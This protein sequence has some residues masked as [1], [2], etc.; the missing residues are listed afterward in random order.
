MP[1]FVFN[2]LSNSMD[3]KAVDLYAEIKVDS[4]DSPGLKAHHER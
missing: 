4:N 3:F 1:D 2:M